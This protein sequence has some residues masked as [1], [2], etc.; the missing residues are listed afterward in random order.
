MEDI[1]G[2]PEFAITELGIIF[3]RPVDFEIWQILGDKLMF[4]HAGLQWML[5]DWLLYGEKAS[6]SEQFAQAL[7]A[8]QIE[9]STLMNYR[10]VASIFPIGARFAG[11]SWSHHREVA[12]L[13]PEQQQFWLKA[14]AENKWSIRDMLQRMVGGTTGDGSIDSLL[15]ATEG[16]RKVL[17]SLMGLSKEDQVWV[18][19]QAAEK[20]GL[21]INANG[22]SV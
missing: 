21:M 9:Y 1:L 7:D 14:A 12:E 5:G 2:R 3:R 10:R 22:E 11:V 20:L 6:W 15:S 19:Q 16:K 17:K 4:Y 18:I 8:F 13:N